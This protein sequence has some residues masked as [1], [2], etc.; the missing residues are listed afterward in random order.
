MPMVKKYPTDVQR[1]GRAEANPSA[2]VIQQILNYSKALEVK[3]IKH[4][5]VLLNLN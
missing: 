2:A 1:D 3:K 5:R 4:K